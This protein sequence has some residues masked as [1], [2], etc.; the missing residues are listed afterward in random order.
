L[1]ST[2]HQILPATVFGVTALNLPVNIL[3]GCIASAMILY[4]SV[5]LSMTMELLGVVN[6]AHVVFA[7]ASYVRRRRAFARS[8]KRTL[9]ML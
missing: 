5:A 6:L 8:C 7:M 4:M 3:F 1:G 2:D 9:L